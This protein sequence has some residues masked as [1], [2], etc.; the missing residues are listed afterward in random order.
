MT[1]E[2]AKILAEAEQAQIQQFTD[3]VKGKTHEQLNALLDGLVAQHK[4]MHEERVK[5]AMKMVI[6]AQEIRIRMF[7]RAF[8]SIKVEEVTLIADLLPSDHVVGES[9]EIIKRIQAANL[10]P[11][12]LQVDRVRKTIRILE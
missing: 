12:K 6:L 9:E 7:R 10:T 4:P 5:L 11:S 1:P 8:P 3:S 2:E